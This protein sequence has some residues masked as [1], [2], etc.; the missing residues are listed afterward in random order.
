MVHCA[1]LHTFTNT[2]SFGE[3]SRICQFCPKFTS[4][5]NGWWFACQAC[6]TSVS[7][8][9]SYEIIWWS[10]FFSRISL[11]IFPSLMAK[12]GGPL[13]C[14]C[15]QSQNPQIFGLQFLLRFADL[16]QMW[17]FAD[18][19][20]A[21]LRFLL[22]AGLRFAGSIIFC[23]LTTC[24]NPQIHNVYPY[25]YKLRMLSFKVKNDFWL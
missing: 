9:H 4:C 23:G 18:L 24:A 8:W 11:Y 13:I 10:P 17:Q 12:L 2:D 21:D 1:V 16:P 6:P 20:F 25:K 22:F 7:A 15:R 5:S 19:R 14:K 3:I